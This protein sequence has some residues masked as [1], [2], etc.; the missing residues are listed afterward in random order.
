MLTNLYRAV[1]GKKPGVL[2]KVGL[3]TFVDPRIE[4]GKVN[5]KAT[6]DLV[7]VVEL[8]GEEWLFLKAFPIL[9]KGKWEDQQIISAYL[10]FGKLLKSYDIISSIEV[11][12]RFPVL[13]IQL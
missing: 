5:T 6:K 2:S 3:G 9:N 13:S 12:T 4:G 11:L 7:E 8:V 1:A 10:N